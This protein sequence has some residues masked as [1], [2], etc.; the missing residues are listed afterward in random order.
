MQSVRDSDL[1]RQLDGTATQEIPPDLFLSNL[2]M[3]SKGGQNPEKAKAFVKN[4]KLKN[5]VGIEHIIVVNYFVPFIATIERFMLNTFDNN[6]N[7]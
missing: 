5:P 1:V 4:D 6:S 7:S 2:R 3:A